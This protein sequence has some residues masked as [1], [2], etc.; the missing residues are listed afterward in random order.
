MKTINQ[1]ATPTMYAN[2]GQQ[3]EL[4]ATYTLVGELRK[5]DK[6]PFDVGSDIPELACSVKSARFT[7]AS[8]LY[9][10]TL[11][12]MVEDYFNRVHST[13]WAYVA[14]DGCIYMMN[15]TEFAEF[16]ALFTTLQRASS[17]NGGGMVVRMRSESK[18]VLKWLAE[19]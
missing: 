12:E 14:N 16:L 2:H 15:K 6:V 17:K 19:H 5:A 1:I 4:I 7:L 3:C 9:G 13:V 18:A 8:K 11:A 10:N